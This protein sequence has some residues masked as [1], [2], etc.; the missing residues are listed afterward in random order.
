MGPREPGRAEHVAAWGG[1]R[2]PGHQPASREGPQTFLC[3]TPPTSV[4][5]HFPR[6]AVPGRVRRQRP[7]RTARLPSASAVR[8]VPEA[9]GQK[10]SFLVAFHQML[11]LNFPKGFSQDVGRAPGLRGAPQSS[12]SRAPSEPVTRSPWALASVPAAWQGDHAAPR[13][14]GLSAQPCSPRGPG[15]TV[16]RQLP[17]P[18]AHKDKRDHPSGEGTAWPWSVADMRGLSWGGGV[19]AG[20]RCPQDPSS[21]GDWPCYPSSCWGGGGCRPWA[22]RHPQSW[23]RAGAAPPEAL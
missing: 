12:S 6:E 5:G 17:R 1:H 14:G 3:C 4:P 19:F 11:L 7:G 18:P 15:L 21:T 2:V 16:H 23:S 9:H 13:Q 10:Q 8:S 22:P 20:A